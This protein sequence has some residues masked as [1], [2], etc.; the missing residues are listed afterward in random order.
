MFY[1]SN[2]ATNLAIYLKTGSDFMILW[3][4]LNL[5]DKLSTLCSKA[6]QKPS[7][8]D[9]KDHKPPHNVAFDDVTGLD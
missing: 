3:L 7:Q 4:E 2:Y 8:E 1:I 6:R 9:R 5:H